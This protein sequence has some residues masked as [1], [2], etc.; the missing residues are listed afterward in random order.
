[1]VR[2]RE[3]ELPIDRAEFAKKAE[4]LPYDPWTAED[5]E[6]PER[7]RDPM[8]RPIGRDIRVDEE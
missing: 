5:E 2:K 3:E 4:D 8:R 1:M 6:S 7:R